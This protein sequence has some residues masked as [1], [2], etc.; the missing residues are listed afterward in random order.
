MTATR[1]ELIVEPRWEV[2][3]NHIAGCKIAVL[4]RK[5]CGGFPIKLLSYL[6]L[7]L[8]VVISEGSSQGLPGEIPIP[9]EQFAQ[10]I[11]SALDS[12]PP[13]HA[14]TFLHENAW[15]RRAQELTKLYQSLI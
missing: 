5:F 12:P 6:G 13:T 8:P 4:P 14:P 10:G 11:Q 15:D 1:T 9:P 3:R 2:A 7:G